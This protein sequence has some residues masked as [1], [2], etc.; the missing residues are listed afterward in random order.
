MITKIFFY[1]Y[2]S[3][4][5]SLL[6]C[7]EYIYSP[8]DIIEYI[9]KKVEYTNEDY[10][11]FIDNLSKTF[12][13]SYAF[14]DI[15]KN[16]PQP[17]FSSNYHTKINIQ[18]ELNEIDLT[19]ITPYEFYRKIMTILSE[20]KDSHIQMNWKPLNLDKFFILGP[21]DYSIKEDEEGNI[22]IYGQCID[23]LEDFENSEDIGEIC[24]DYSD[25]PI[26]Y[27]NNLDPFEYINNFGGNF[28]STKNVH[29]TFSFKLRYHN[30]VPLSDYPLS[31]EDLE[32]YKVE[33]ESGDSF[34]TGLLIASDVDIDED[35]LR[36][37]DSKG[38]IHKKKILK[39]NKSLN[40]KNS[41]QKPIRFY[42]DLLNFEIYWNYEC[43]DIL[44]CFED[45]TNQINI[46]YITSFQPSDKELFNETL[47]NC[48]KLFDDNIYPIIVINDLN[49][50]G[51]VSLSQIFLG[52]ISPLIPIKLY[53]GRMRITDSF[54]DTEK[55]NEYINLNLTK[56]DDCLD[57]T[58]DY[59]NNG[60]IDVNYEN[61]INSQ[62]TELFYI[63]N[64]SIQYDIENSRNKMNN[65]RKPTDIIIYTDGYSFSAS[66]LFIKYL[67]DNGGGIIVQYLGNPKKEDEIF[68]ISQSPSPVFSSNLLKIFSEDNYNKLLNNHEC[69]LQMPGIQTFYNKNNSNIPLE[70]EVST[71]DEKS[72][73]Y[74]DFDGD[75]YQ[76]FIDKAKE[77]FDK[78]KNECN[79]NNKN[80][81]KIS[82]ECDD[83]F[84][85]KYT[86]GGYECGDDGKWSN[87]C[88]ASY[89]DSGYTFD[90][91]NK[92]CI[93]D[94]C[95]SVEP[96]EN[97]KENEEEKEEEK[98]KEK[99]E[100]KE[101][102]K[103]KEKEN[104]KENEKEKAKLYSRKKGKKSKLALYIA[105]PISLLLLLA[106]VIFLIIYRIKYYNKRSN[107]YQNKEKSSV[108]I[109]I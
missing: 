56:M 90:K 79:S 2:F 105:L 23:Q 29:G 24:L 7:Q 37:L 57:C 86:H 61:D 14:N 33:F 96:E 101:K 87:N 35:R 8:S 13:D 68:D 75:R 42:K 88:V 92:K 72:G 109:N 80:L 6:K 53:S 9:N 17:Y 26:K 64:K 36:N 91:I 59:L 104:E 98:E 71:P 81:L 11:S 43:E 18:K 76:K 48:Y 73:I 89:C 60:K 3:F 55:I 108:H 22:K 32:N 31:L 70:Y 83:T 5:L 46:Y 99:E 49:N 84:N 67:K 34:E 21:I 97:G 10:L 38:K 52:I 45:K 107:D 74:E 54:K 106:V 62:L 16:P 25:T 50:G 65:K 15:C 58:Y 95:S 44:K 78:Y 77:I 66:S 20:L 4:L 82:E 28:L 39:N 51:Y 12:S 1:I 63:N 103:E 19:D 69:E 94:S 41:K 27:I 93:K 30:S 47:E 100:E 40:F 102:E 85:N